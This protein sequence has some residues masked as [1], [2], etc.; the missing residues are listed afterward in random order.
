MSQN[1]QYVYQ[2]FDYVWPTKL[3]DKHNVLSDYH[4]HQ[5]LCLIGLLVQDPVN[6]FLLTTNFFLS[7]SSPSSVLHYISPVSFSLMLIC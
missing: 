5:R 3:F 2:M 4:I 6:T 7:P 1:L